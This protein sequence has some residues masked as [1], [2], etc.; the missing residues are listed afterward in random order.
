MAEPGLDV[1]ALSELGLHDRVEHLDIALAGALGPVQGG[2]GLAQQVECAR[3][4]R[5]VRGDSG[6]RGHVHVVAVDPERWAQAGHDRPGQF[7]QGSPVPPRCADGHELVGANPPQEVT[8]A[9]GFADPLGHQRQDQV[10][11]LVAQAVVDQGK[12]V[13]VDVYGPST[14]L[15]PGDEFVK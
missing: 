13:D 2:V 1:E 7:G 5:A 10:P 6:R 8:A 3:G 15:A 9:Q 12:I 4:V 11:D 14:A